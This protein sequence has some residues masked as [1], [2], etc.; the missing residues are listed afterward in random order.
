MAEAQ[1]HI[2]FDQSGFELIHW[3]PI[4]KQV[5]CTLDSDHSICVK[6]VKSKPIIVL[7]KGSVHLKLNLELFETICGLNESVKLVKCFLE[8]HTL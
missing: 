6:M 5:E 2:E 4:L 3:S 8:G 7:K 1:L